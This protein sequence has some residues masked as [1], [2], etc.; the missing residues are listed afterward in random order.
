MLYQ[1]VVDSPSFKKVIRL[2]NSCYSIG[3]HPSNTIVIPSPQI[4]RRHATLIKKI[5]PNLDI[6]FHIIDGD[7]E[8]HRSRNGVWVNGESH[9]DY[10]LV[11]GDVIALS[12]DI[13][14]FYQAIPT[15][16]KDT[17]SGG[18]D[19]QRLTPDLSEHFPQEQWDI[20]LI[21]HE[22]DLSQLSHEQLS[23]LAACI[24]YSPYPMVEIDYF[25]NLTYLN[26]AT[27][28]KFPSIRE[29]SMT[30]P[31]LRDVIPQREDAPTYYIRTREVQIG[32]KFYEQ[33]IH[34]PAESQFIRSYIFDIT[35]RKVIEQSIHYQAFY[36]PL[37]DLPNRFLFKQ[38]LGKVLS[39]VQNQ[40][41]VLGLVLLGFREL[42]SLN[43]LLGHSVADE[44]LKIITERLSAH[45]RLEDL[46]CRWRGD[47]FILLIQSCR[48]LDEI[49][50]FVRRLLAVLKRPFFIANNPLYLQGYAGIACYPNHGD[51]VETLLNRVGVALNE[52][53]DIGSRQYCFY[54]ESM[55]SDHLERIQLE[56]ALHQAL[57]KDEF[58]LY[59]QPI[60][61]V[62]A[63]RLC[64]VE[65]LIRWQHPFQGL[66][67]PGL[68]IGLLETTGLIIPVGEWIMRTAFQHFHNW[69][70]AVDD[71]FRIAINLSPQQFQA[72]DLL[73][74][75]LRILE[76]SSLAPHRLEVEITENIVMQNVTATQ[77]LLNALQSHGI[78]LSMD[79]F[80]T[81]YS[82][83][84]YLKTFPFNTLKIDRSFTKD[85]LHTPKDA[86]IIQAI[87]LLGN[88]FNL[89][90]IAEGIEEESQARCL[91]DL[92]C[93]EMQ[94]YWFSHPLSE[95]EITAFLAEGNFQRFCLG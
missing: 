31:L 81:G 15:D 9:L 80:G 65:A 33:H 35:E 46:L 62:Q 72:P 53:K 21:G 20:T 32:D 38:E 79:D 13:Q 64:G 25:G 69:A 47:T 11:H 22:D 57:E 2:Q 61:D 44:V 42:Q 85:I 16:P 45:V 40:S 28:E 70:P 7:L 73:P 83:L 14:I 84:S 50:V 60:I 87:L 19:R 49:E 24:E 12:E 5:N 30:H 8:G 37:T 1:L 34:Y 82:S 56:H 26:T 52:V 29:D 39:N 54:E 41:S 91:Y 51:N 67:P 3:R 6:S 27:K 59:Y 95:A 86:A 68:F 36:D 88:G 55:N 74:T 23:K 94:G 43:D 90:I 78:R 75:I 93:R 18:G 92:G 71:D 58:L 48:N 76:E 66:V 17:I 4:S 89:N 63:G 77:N 10:E